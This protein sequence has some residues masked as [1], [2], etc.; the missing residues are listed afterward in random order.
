MGSP[1]ICFTT[2]RQ[3]TNNWKLPYKRQWKCTS[4][5]GIQVD[6]EHT[7]APTVLWLRPLL[8]YFYKNGL[9]VGPKL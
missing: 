4:K 1:Y 9:I 2:S 6:S 5:I 8:H 7:Y 3:E